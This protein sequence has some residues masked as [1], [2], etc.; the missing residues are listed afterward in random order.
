MLVCI[1]MVDGANRAW[2]SNTMLMGL[3]HY[4]ER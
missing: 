2:L 1:D 4:K 3:W